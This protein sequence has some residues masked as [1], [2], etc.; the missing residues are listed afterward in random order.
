MIATAL[1]RLASA[2]IA[3]APRGEQ[4]IDDPPPGGDVDILLAAPDAA[5]AERVLQAAGFPRFDVVG[6]DGHR[7]HLAFDSERARWLKIDVNVIPRRLRWD[8]RARDHESL[9]RFARFRSRRGSRVRVA[10]E[11]RLPLALARRGTVIAVLGPD[12]AGKSSVLARLRAEIPVA[13]TI[14]Y[15]GNGAAAAR[16]RPRAGGVLRA[17]AQWLPEGPRIAQ[18]RLRRTLYAAWRVWRA[19][20]Y[21][22]RG[23]IVLC[24][25]HPLEALAL[26]P[27][28][29]GL[30]GRLGRLIP[31]PDEIVILDAPGTVLFARKGE[32]SP[33]RLEQWRWAYRR[34]FAP[35]GAS[36]VSTASDMTTSVAAVSAI[37]WRGLKARRG[38]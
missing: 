4:P 37:V 31:W 16:K 8:L 13:V 26:D 22:W 18:F 19:H 1:E 36:I 14:V 23:D 30:S 2:G 7:F 12:G 9:R 6:H 32:H 38:W 3:F 34:A 28:A 5:A 11:R 24:D 25:R 21:A 27:E 17:A 15:M 35:H 20:A 29:S 10:I 33:E